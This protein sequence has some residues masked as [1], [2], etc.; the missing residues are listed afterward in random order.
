MLGAGLSCKSSSDNI[1]AEEINTII[2]P[3][4]ARIIKPPLSK[5]LQTLQDNVFFWSS[6]HSE[7]I[8]CNSAGKV[9]VN[10]VFLDVKFSEITE[11]SDLHVASAQLL[12][13]HLKSPKI[14]R[15]L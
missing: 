6:S 5:A 4:F 12:C 13:L 3:S 15:L 7:S 11:V 1:Q 14:H 9:R 8:Y 2:S 10:K